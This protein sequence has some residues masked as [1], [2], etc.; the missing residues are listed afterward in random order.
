MMAP[1]GEGMLIWASRMMTALGGGGVLQ[2]HFCRTTMALST[3]VEP[4]EPHNCDPPRWFA[5]PTICMTW[6]GWCE[7]VVL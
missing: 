5:P 3:R 6:H 1:L 7:F 2:G 4:G